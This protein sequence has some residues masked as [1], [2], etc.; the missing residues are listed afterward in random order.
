MKKPHILI[1]DDDHIARTAIAFILENAGYETSEAFSGAQALKMLKA[2][3]HKADVIILD[4]MMPEM[5]G[6]D[7]L[8]KIH[9]IPSL[10]SIPI[11]MLTAHA[12]RDHVKTA[13][14]YGVFDVIF[15]PV[16]E[17]LLCKVLERALVNDKT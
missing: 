16:D 7:V 9:D 11:I 12:E 10:R 1:V 5:C 8:Q 15:K 4:R 14:I 13:T 3:P 6:I 2:L 17:V